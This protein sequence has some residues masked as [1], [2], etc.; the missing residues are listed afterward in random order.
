MPASLNTLTAAENCC[1]KLHTLS[2]TVCKETR[3][4]RLQEAPSDLAP[5]SLERF[6]VD[7]SELEHRAMP[8]AKSEVR[9]P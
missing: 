6:V 4:R 7:A 3:T 2:R 1:S 5:C 9:Q 8:D